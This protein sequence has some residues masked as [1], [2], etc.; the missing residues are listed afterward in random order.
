MTL[1]ISEVLDKKLEQ[2]LLER[3]EAF[4]K[5]MISTN[6]SEE[7]LLEDFDYYVAKF[8]ETVDEDE[9]QRFKATFFLMASNSILEAI[10]KELQRLNIYTPAL[11]DALKKDLVEGSA[12]ILRDFGS[13]VDAA[14]ERYT[15][16]YYNVLS[17]GKKTAAEERFKR[18]ALV[19]AAFYAINAHNALFVSMEKRHLET[20]GITTF[21]WG[22]QRDFKVRGTHEE[23]EG[24]EFTNEGVCVE[25]SYTPSDGKHIVPKQEPNCRCYKEVSDKRYTEAILNKYGR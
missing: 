1:Q 23:R 15:E 16:L 25:T 11:F 18:L 9:V 20:L 17:E 14:L 3:N 7:Q 5:F 22:T 4:R 19:V 10:K 24:Y 13:D 21:L 8:L 12:T 2:F 6:L